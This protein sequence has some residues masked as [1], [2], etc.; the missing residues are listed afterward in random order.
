MKLSLI[1][2][3]Y[4]SA[5][6]IERTI[7][8]ILKQNILQLEYL[9]IDGDSSDSTLSIVQSYVSYFGE[10]GWSIRIYSEK[11][12]GIYDAFNKGISHSTGD[13]IGII[14]SDDE[15]EE[16]A[17]PLIL[18]KAKTETGN[19]LIYGFIRHIKNNKEL[20]IVRH[21]YSNYLLDLSMGIYSA[22]QHP[23]CFVTRSLYND[24]GVFNTKYKTA[25][26]YDLLL[27]FARANV[28][29]IPLNSILVNFYVGGASYRV[30]QWYLEYQKNEILFSN[31]LILESKYK[32]RKIQIMKIKIKFLLKKRAINLVN[33]YITPDFLKFLTQG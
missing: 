5:E 33:K 2:A 16:N 4:N 1:T 6:T 8:S 14:N 3:T 29:F 28:H 7:V 27:R 23:T 25:A 21:N 11:D 26:D 30:D 10:K 12:E 17:L 32:K 19:Y 24:L 18:E 9:V 20:Q 22:A 15:L 31:K 13:L